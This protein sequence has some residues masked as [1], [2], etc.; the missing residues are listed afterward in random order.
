[1]YR[2]NHGKRFTRSADMWRRVHEAYIIAAP[3]IVFRQG[4]G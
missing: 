2:V 4:L 1:M 3:S